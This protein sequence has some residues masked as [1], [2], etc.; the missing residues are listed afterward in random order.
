M[1]SSQERKETLVDYSLALSWRRSG[2]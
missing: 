1:T 2:F